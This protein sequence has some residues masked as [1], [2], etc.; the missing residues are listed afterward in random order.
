MFC[1]R[2]SS[3]YVEGIVRCDECG[4]RIGCETRP[5][6]NGAWARFAGGDTER[7]GIDIPG[8]RRCGECN[9]ARKKKSAAS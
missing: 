6:E 3:E 5:E 8:G 7:E 4:E 9:A 1:P 2:C